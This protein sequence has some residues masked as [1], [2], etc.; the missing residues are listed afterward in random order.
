MW[1][2]YKDVALWKLFDITDGKSSVLSWVENVLPTPVLLPAVTPRQPVH[3]DKRLFHRKMQVNLITE[4]KHSSGHLPITGST[5]RIHSP[6]YSDTCNISHLQDMTVIRRKNKSPTKSNHIDSENKTETA[7]RHLSSDS[8]AIFSPE[9]VSF[10][11][12][13]S[14]CGS[15]WTGDSAVT[16]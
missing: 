9:L 1:G 11:I 13:K 4:Q 8:M 12:Y 14:V 3:P 6:L 2:S 10:Q 15:F 5:S 7:P 16:D